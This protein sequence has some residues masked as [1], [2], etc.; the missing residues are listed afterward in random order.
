M[1]PNRTNSDQPSRNLVTRHLGHAAGS[2]ALAFA[3]WWT[4]HQTRVAGPASI[5]P[6]A[7]PPLI[8]ATV[9][10]VVLAT[11]WRI[12]A[13]A[14]S[15][16]GRF[17][18]LERLSRQAT[19]PPLRRV[20]DGCFAAVITGSA[21]FTAMPAGAQTI[22][23]PPRV[24]VADQSEAAPL[25]I[26]LP[27][28]PGGEIENWL[29]GNPREA[30]V[31]ERHD[32]ARVSSDESHTWTDQKSTGAPSPPERSPAVPSDAPPPATRF[33]TEPSNDP[34]LDQRD[35]NFTGVPYAEPAGTG[36]PSDS[37]VVQSGDSLWRIA[38]HRL[39]DRASIQAIDSYWRE[40]Y[41]ANAGVIGE[42]P[43]LIRP[44]TELAIPRPPGADPVEAAR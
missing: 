42:N 35:S 41:D 13:L 2:T 20:I 19:F 44:G 15:R 16:R 9:A 36:M 7:T 18:R 10:Y 39:A 37:Y 25:Q 12:G 1:P 43:S 5:L 32:P 34:S 40:I 30:R 26:Q 38:S 21:L 31:E 23:P 27:E 29:S 6:A 17:G 3:F 22:A 28:R 24:A 14:L 8:R 33:E 4:Y 11:M